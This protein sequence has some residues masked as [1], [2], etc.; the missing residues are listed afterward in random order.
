MGIHSVTFVTEIDFSTPLARELGEATLEDYLSTLVRR[1]V[2]LLQAYPAIP[3]LYQA[4]IRYQH[5]P[6]GVEKWQAIDRMLV[7]KLADCEDLA[8][9]L[10]AELIVRRGDKK[11]KP[12]LT[13]RPM[14]N[15]ARMYHIRTQHGDGTIEDPSRV[16]GMGRTDQ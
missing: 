10:A 13:S 3:P 5:E 16:L 1:N 7:T 15:S 2:R 6:P 11:A 12:V 9:A 4:G 8:C 14:G